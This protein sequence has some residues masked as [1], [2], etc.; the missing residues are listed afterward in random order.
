MR[1]AHLLVAGLVAAGRAAHAEPDH[2]ASAAHSRVAVRDADTDAS[3]D[4]APRVTRRADGVAPAHRGGSDWSFAVSPYVWAADVDL[5]VSF[6]PLTTGASL[7]HVALARHTRFGAEGAAEA[8]LGRLGLYGDLMYGESAFGVA[9]ER[10][11]AMTTITGAAG[12]LLVDAG[13]GYEVLGG[14]ATAFSLE[15][16][17][18]VR[19]QRT[20]VRGELGAAKMTLKSPE[21]VD[22][23]ADAL[24]GLGAKLRLLPALQLAGTIDVGAVG[25]SDRTWSVTV[26]GSLRLSNRF[27]LTAGWRTLTIQRSSVSQ[28]L[29]GPRVALKYLF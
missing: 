6:G 4:A 7:G 11:P 2:R 8:H 22:D 28:Q 1:A 26:D 19:Y 24:V 27:S 29:H 21:L 14:E 23:G 16:R 17:Y 9:T 13:L 20:T 5:G 10:A 15:A 18:G 25:A 3:A 12:A